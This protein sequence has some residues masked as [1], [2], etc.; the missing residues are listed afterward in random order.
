M[1]W[2]SSKLC[3]QQHIMEHKTACAMSLLECFRNRDILDRMKDEGDVTQAAVQ[4]RQNKSV[5]P[6]VCLQ[7]PIV[8]CSS[9]CR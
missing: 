2:G 6:G 5:W 9:D 7:W 1:D 3:H 4:I 8:A